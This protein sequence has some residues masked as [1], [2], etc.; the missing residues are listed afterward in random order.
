MIF[1]EPT[2]GDWIYFLGF[3]DDGQILPLSADK[4]RCQ[5]DSFVCQWFALRTVEPFIFFLI[6]VKLRIAV[7]HGLAVELKILRSTQEMRGKYWN[8]AAGYRLELKIRT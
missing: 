7:S 6:S 3:S 1:L 4:D 5:P 8:L 2:A